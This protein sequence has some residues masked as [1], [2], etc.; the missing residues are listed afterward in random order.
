MQQLSPTKNTLGRVGIALLIGWLSN[1]LTFFCVAS[2][3][4]E[5]QDPSGSGSGFAIAA[6]MII[7][8]VLGILGALIAAVAA[9]IIGNA[10][11]KELKDN[12]KIT[13]VIILVSAV[14]GLIVGL[15]AILLFNVWASQP[16]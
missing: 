13:K 14:I 9:F 8:P 12:P 2:S 6:F 11:S 16:A 7:A 10:S 15:I 3:V 1:C 5:Y 4:A